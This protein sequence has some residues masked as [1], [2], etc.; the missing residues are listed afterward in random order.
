MQDINTIRILSGDQ[1]YEKVR[2]ERNSARDEYE[3]TGSRAALRLIKK[4]DNALE[5]YE[6]TK[7]IVV[8][9]NH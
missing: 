5:T 6:R 1:E 2:E 4:L 9:K 7:N 3:K 8:P